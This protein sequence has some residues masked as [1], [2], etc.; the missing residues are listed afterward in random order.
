MTSVTSTYVITTEAIVVSSLPMFVG[1]A[2]LAADGFPLTLPQFTV[3]VRFQVSNTANRNRAVF[4]NGGSVLLRFEDP[5]ND[6]SDHKAHSLA[7]PRRR[8]VSQSVVVVHA[9]QMAASGA[10][11]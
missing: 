10:D 3:E 6:T 4:T 11:L 7:V 1:G 8:L 9:Q 5:Q 2:G